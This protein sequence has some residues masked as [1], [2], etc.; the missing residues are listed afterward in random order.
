[1]HTARHT[2]HAMPTD[3]R[4]DAHVE[5]EHSGP[6]STYNHPKPSNVTAT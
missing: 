5:V 1:M 3:R 2:R 4:I 6:N